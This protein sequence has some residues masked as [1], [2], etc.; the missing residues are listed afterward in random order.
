MTTAAEYY[1]INK[2]FAAYVNK[3]AAKHGIS[4]EQALGHRLITDAHIYY[5][6]EESKCGDVTEDCQIEK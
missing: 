4:V 6:E 2:D 1:K 3:Y 5:D